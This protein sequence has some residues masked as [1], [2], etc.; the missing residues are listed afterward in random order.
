[1]RIQIANKLKPFSHEAGTFLLLPG[2]QLRF[3]IFPVC[4]KVCDLS[5]PIPK[6]IEEISLPIVGPVDEFTIQLDIE[7]G[8]IHVWGTSSLGYFRYRIHSVANEPDWRLIVEKSP[9]EK[10]KEIKPFSNELLYKPAE[11][12]ERLTLGSHKKQDWTM[13]LRR[14]NVTEI[15]P[16]WFSLAQM[17]CSMPIHAPLQGTAALLEN[18]QHEISQDDPTVRLKSFQSLF[19]VGFEGLLSPRLIDEQYH[20]FSFPPISDQKLS[21]LIL[22][23]E[24][25]KLIRTLFIENRGGEIQ[26]LPHLPTQFHCGRMTNLVC[27]DIVIDLE[28]SKKEIRRMILRPLRS[29]EVHLSFPKGVKTYRLRQDKKERGFKINCNESI[30]LESRNIY[31]LDHFKR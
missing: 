23:T 7:K 2:S 11:R 21:P 16:Y 3:Q 25:A 13:V 30:A 6:P 5:Q 24:G 27:E 4:L 8:F 22:L 9:D 29:C 14:K 1:M 31:F 17:F 15:F 19:A 20:G 26:I 12:R 28:W 10:L 18:C